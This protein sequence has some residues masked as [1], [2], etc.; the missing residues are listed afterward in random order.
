[1]WH[2]RSLKGLGHFQSSSFWRFYSMRFP[3]YP[4]KENNEYVETGPGSRCGLE[5]LA[6]WLR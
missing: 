3:T 6:L 4:R 1:M 5:L 2:N